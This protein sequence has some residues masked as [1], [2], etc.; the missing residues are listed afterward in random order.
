MA[1]P[2]QLAANRLN[3]AKSTGPTSSAGLAVSRFNAL[4]S[5]IDAKAQVIPGEDPSALEALA[6]NYRQQ[7]QPATP[8]EIFLLD[9][10]VTAD[11]QLRRLRKI[12]PLLWSEEAFER[13]DSKEAKRLAR[14]HRRMDAAERSY[15]RALRELQKSVAA[16]TAAAQQAA[17]TQESA[18]Q[19]AELASFLQ[20]ANATP[21][22][23]RQP[24]PAP[25]RDRASHENLALRL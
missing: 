2:A 21:A 11:W 8:V 10:L 22:A 20:T 25:A 18:P 12:E 24:A 9:A 1:T 3:S 14:L 7:F 13:P 16:R 15:Y 6:E 23:I 19:T 17:Q 4:Q 5:G